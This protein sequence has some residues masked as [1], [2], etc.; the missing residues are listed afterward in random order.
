M[1]VVCLLW[2]RLLYIRIIR[3]VTDYTELG[4]KYLFETELPHH[5]KSILSQF[6][7]NDDSVQISS[8]SYESIY[9]HSPQSNTYHVGLD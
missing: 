2:T 6:T 9:I 3:Y 5:I 8:A 7:N 4:L 1:A